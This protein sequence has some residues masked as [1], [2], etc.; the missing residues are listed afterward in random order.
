[1][2][3]RALIAC[4]PRLVIADFNSE[5]KEMLENADI[6]IVADIDVKM[7]SYYAA[8]SEDDLEFAL[9]DTERANF[10]DWLV[11]YKNRFIS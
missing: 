5:I 11:D 4:G 9:K 6:I 3:A 2:I 1:M 7:A 8:V 10:L